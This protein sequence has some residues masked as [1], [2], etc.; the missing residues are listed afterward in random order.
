[1]QSCI[2]CEQKLN[3]DIEKALNFPKKIK[4]FWGGI[5]YASILSND[6]AIQP[7]KSIVQR[8]DRIRIWHN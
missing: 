4:S 3:G 5:I 8:Q 1:M 2:A 6:H 7:Q